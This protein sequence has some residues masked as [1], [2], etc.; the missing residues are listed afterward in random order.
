[1][2]LEPGLSS[3]RLLV[4][5]RSGDDDALNALL[6]R[7]L[8]RLRR[9][10]QGRLPLSAR[11][12]VDTDDVVQDAAIAALRH[13]GSIEIHDAG[14]LQAYL[15]QAVANR[16]TDMYRRHARRPERID[17]PADLPGREPSPLEMALGADALARYEGALQ[18][19]GDDDREAIVMRLE[20]DCSY[21]DIAETLGKNS[22]ASAR[23]AVSRA[24]AR[25]AREMA[26]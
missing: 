22:E 9:W 13:L 4:H 20:M 11:Q 5:A 26:R 23:M 8:P 16:I 2:T 12:G 24:L 25:L 7:Y 15:R 17:L 14:S 3:V 6:A 10:A 19:L 1:M 18:R 21:G